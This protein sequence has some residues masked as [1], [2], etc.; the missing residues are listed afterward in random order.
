MIQRGIIQPGETL[1][2]SLERTVGALVELDTELNGGRDEQFVETVVDYVNDGTIVFGTPVMTN[3]GRENAITAACTVLPVRVE[4]GRVNMSRFYHD[5]EAALDKAVGTGY[6]LSELDEPAKALVE[7]NGALDEIN[8]HLVKANQRPVASMATLRADHPGVVDFIRAKRGADFSKWRFNI[9]VFLSEELF[10]AAAEGRAWDLRDNDGN[11]VDSIDAETLLTEIAEC[12]HYCGEPGILFKDRID[13]DNPTPQWE[14]KSTAPCAEVAMAEGEACQFSYVNV[15]ELF[16]KD[17]TF[18]VEKFGS[19]VRVMTRLLDASV[20]HTVRNAEDFSLPLVEQKRRIG[21]G[22]TGFAD[23]LINLGIPY[24][25]PRAATLAAQMSEALDFHSKVESAELAK[26]RGAFPA[27]PISRFLEPE[28]LRRKLPYSTGAITE[29]QWEKLFS[30]INEHG[31]RHASTTAMPP[32]GTSSAIVGS[33][34]SL[35]PLFVITDHHG[36]VSRVVMEALSRSDDPAIQQ[37]LGH[38]SLT[39][40]DMLDADMLALVPH[41]RTAR[42]VNSTAHLDVQAGFQTFLD[43]SLAKT[44]NLPQ[45]ATVADV[46]ASLQSAYNSRL[47]GI[48]VF[49]DNCL[50]E[51]TDGARV[52]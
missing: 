21:V 45:T 25:D 44:I 36:V 15:S 39:G 6:D 11:V 33:S 42:Q 7:L 49:R 5:S 19:A 24:D 31:I 32:T 18:D 16:G 37:I 27:F 14:Y 28:W 48:T 23:L 20:E 29:E 30:D 12:A 38:I 22:I 35:E 41:L 9:S 3:A 34:K 13:A 51:R 2:G 17:G 52:G 1:A 46:R 10:E 40:P 26:Q 43:E 4:E 8:T 50:S 47:K